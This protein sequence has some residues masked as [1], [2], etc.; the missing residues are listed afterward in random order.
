MVSE[1]ARPWRR[2]RSGDCDLCRPLKHSIR[3]RGSS[4]LEVHKVKLLFCLGIAGKTEKKRVESP[5]LSKKARVCKAR[6]PASL[7]GF[8]PSASTLGPQ[9]CIPEFDKVCAR[10]W[11]ARPLEALQPAVA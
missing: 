11:G 7:R 1:G 6:D 3:S 9:I 10:F 4:L 2:G 5:Y 8:Q